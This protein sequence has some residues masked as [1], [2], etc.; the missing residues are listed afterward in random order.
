MLRPR[1]TTTTP[2]IR[3]VPV[4]D[5]V[6]AREGIRAILTLDRGIR[7][8]GEADSRA[9]AI[10]EVHRTKPDVVI[11]DMRLPDGTGYDSCRDILSAFPRTRILFFSA[12]S[13][14]NALYDAV[15]AGG[16]GY[17][18][19]DTEAKDLL[20]AIKTIAAGQSLLGPQ[21]AARNLSRKEEHPT[22]APT[23]LPPI[24]S[25][26][27]LT[28]LSLLAKGATNKAI[29]VVL[30]KEPHTIVTLQSALYKKLRVTRRA[31]AVHHFITQLSQHYPPLD[32]TPISA[33][34]KG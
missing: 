1:S 29:A 20:R 5:S 23:A 13:D 30:K 15:M 16:H 7:V 8:V 10:K 3:V 27:D 22:N 17:L 21:E 9:R 12:Y 24:L 34:G 6:F 14:D 25:R 31:Q 28:L 33:R 26:I 18:T 2:P 19:K 4:D 11:M 32:I